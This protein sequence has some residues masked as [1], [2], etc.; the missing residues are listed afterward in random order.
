MKRWIGA[1]IMATAVLHTVVGLMFASKPLMDVLNAGIFNAVDPHFDRMAAVWFL[2]F[3]AMLFLLGLFVQ[4]A[5]QETDTL[6]ASVGWGFLLTCVAGVILMPAS[7]FWLGIIEAI[8]MLRISAQKQ[9]VV[10]HQLS[11]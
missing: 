4:W 1:A 3:G 10:S 7:G 9:S 2:L 8:V 11:A 5:L 6:P